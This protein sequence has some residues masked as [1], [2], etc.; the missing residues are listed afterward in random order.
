MATYSNKVAKLA[1]LVPTR[2]LK[3][4]TTCKIYKCFFLNAV[5]LYSYLY[6][7]RCPSVAMDSEKVSKSARISED[8]QIW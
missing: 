6:K 7:I 8:V 3:E 4:S 1:I 2:S 5:N